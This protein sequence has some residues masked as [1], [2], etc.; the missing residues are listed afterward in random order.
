MKLDGMLEELEKK[1]ISSAERSENLALQLKQS[2]ADSEELSQKLSA[3]EA[4]AAALS[5]SLMRVESSL[6][7]SSEDLFKAE[8]QARRRSLEAGLWRIAAL[9]LGSAL[10]GSLLDAVPGRG[11]AWGAGIGAAAGG[12]WLVV[13]LWPKGIK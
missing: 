6:Q 12:V 8:A 11:A 5:S 13:E 3:S 7:A 2:Q 10:A 9:S 1:A 4:R